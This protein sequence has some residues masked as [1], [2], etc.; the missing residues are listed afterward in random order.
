MNEKNVY[1][2]TT[3]RKYEDDEEYF[4]CD[5]IFASEE[6]AKKQ[7]DEDVAE[8]RELYPDAVYSENENKSI[9]QDGAHTFIWQLEFGAL[10]DELFEKEV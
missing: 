7:I 6:V 5:G 1:I 3:L 8:L 10:P 9:L 2:I 4:G